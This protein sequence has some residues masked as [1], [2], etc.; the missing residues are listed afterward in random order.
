MASRLRALLA[1]L[2]VLAS[3]ACQSHAKPNEASGPPVFIEDDFPAAVARAKS[4]HLPLFVD[5][6]A[7]W[8]HTCLAM[9]SSVFGDPVLAPLSSKLV[10]A[11]VDTEKKESA[12]FTDKFA[13]QAWPTLWVIDPASEQ[14][15]LKWPG[16]AT[17]SELVTLL[18]AAI[19]GASGTAESTAAW[20][21]GNREIADGH[22]DAAIAEY[23]R[24]LASAPKN[25]A[26]RGRIVEALVTQL[27]A[28]DRHVDALTL[29]LAEWRSLPRGTSR[30]NVVLTGL[31]AGDSLA[32]DDLHRSDMAGL[33]DEALRIVG[34]PSEPVL[35]DD[36]SSL[37]EEVVSV[38]RSQGN[39]VAAMGTAMK[40]RDFLEAEAARAKT[41]AD[42]AVFDSHRML[43]YAA[44]GTPERAIPMLEQSERDFPSDYN[45]PARLAKTL[46]DLGRLDAALDAVGRAESRVYG[47]R[48]MRVLSIKA[49]IL[50]AMKKPAE[51]K[52]ALVQAVAVGDELKVTGG[53]KELLERIRKR[54][55]EL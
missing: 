39:E 21:R 12:V 34:E 54:A 27:E 35:A 37:F 7:P 42:R 20:V 46:L 47:P 50:E 15:F 24:A 45:P 3:A 10:W 52:A 9:K 25:G 40:W 17:A 6:W 29:A 49:D 41:P 13:M 1:A 26:E 11:S 44:V 23:Q 36:R 16:S 4:A 43:A 22:R 55:V 53:Y 30:L 19:A 33:L 48:T 5:A 8:C 32:K 2:F 38:L 18:Q 31:G 51:A 28:A 14:P